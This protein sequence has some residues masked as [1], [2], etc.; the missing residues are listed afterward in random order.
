MGRRGRPGTGF[1]TGPMVR[2]GRRVQEQKLGPKARTLLLEAHQH[3]RN[4]Q[5]T[6][7]ASE[8]SAVAAIARERAMVRMASFLSAQAAICCAKAGDQQG[9][10]AATELAI[11]DAKIEGDA[12]YSSRTFGA[13]LASL[14]GTPFSNVAVDLDKAIRTALGTVPQAQIKA[15]PNRSMQRHLPTECASCGATFTAGDVSFHDTGRADCPSCG[16]VLDA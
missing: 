7:A 6:E 12:D 13:L 16:S 10:I 5:F 4:N 2:G 1:G 8:L 14:E 3:R 11:T 15:A 9:L